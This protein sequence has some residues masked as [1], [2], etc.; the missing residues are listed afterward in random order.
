MSLGAQGG[1]LFP[2]GAGAFVTIC[3]FSR[4]AIQVLQSHAVIFRQRWDRRPFFVRKNLTGVGDRCILGPVFLSVTKVTTP[5]DPG[6][7]PWKNRKEVWH[8]KEHPQRQGHRRLMMLFT[9]TVVLAASLA[10]TTCSHALYIVTGMEDAAI[11]LDGS[12]RTPDL[13]DRI[14]YNGSGRSGGD[15]T[16]TS[17]QMVRVERDG[18]SVTTRCKTETISQVLERLD[19]VLSPLEMIAVDLSGEE[20]V[21]TIG[22]EI[23]YYDYV[24]EPASYETVRV[25]NPDMLEGEE[26]VVQ[27]GEDGVRASVY[28][29]VWSNGAQISRQFVEELDSTAVDEIIEYGTASPEP[30]PVPAY[31]YIYLN[32]VKNEDGSG[33]LEFADG[34]TLDFSGTKTMTATAYTAGHGG[35]DYTTATGTFVEVGTVAVDRSVIPLGTEMFI[36]TNDGIVYGTAVARDTG[37]RGNVIDLYYNTYRECIEFGRRSCTVYILE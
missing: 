13:G 19:I 26:K 32:I 33:T 30:E 18:Q 27:E 8:L 31:T 36:I 34:T 10:A 17:G 24:T 5:S 23:T 25:A 28:E 3:Y 6:G 16:L 14:V 1:A 7:D 15:V 11:V 9:L 4:G 22:E 20:L 12:R 2:R 21:I 37:V 29:V 35:A